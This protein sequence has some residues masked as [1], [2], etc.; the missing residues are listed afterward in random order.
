MTEVA[1]HLTD[2]VLPG[3]PKAI[4][5]LGYS[6]TP[7]LAAGVQAANATLAETGVIDAALTLRLRYDNNAS[8]LLRRSDHWPFLQNDV[9]AVWFHTELHPDYHTPD[10]DPERIEYYGSSE[11]NGSTLDARSAGTAP[12]KRA[13]PP[14]TAPAI[15]KTRGSVGSTP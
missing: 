7:E 13:T 10:D 3:S 9:P 1:A 2:Q 14:M 15:A 12:A 8:N 4:N 6:R 5:I 11:R